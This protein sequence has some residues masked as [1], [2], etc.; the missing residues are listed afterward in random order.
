MSAWI[1]YRQYASKKS[2]DKF[3]KQTSGKKEG[4][5]SSSIAGGVLRGPPNVSESTHSVGITAQ[6]KQK[7]VDSK[8]Q[9]KRSS[10]QK[11]YGTMMDPKHPPPGTSQTLGHVVSS[12][13]IFVQ[14]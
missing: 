12:D 8:S 13:L 5:G 4:Q 7:P 14:L 6:D 3:D 9:S 10:L 1:H 2:D 11:A